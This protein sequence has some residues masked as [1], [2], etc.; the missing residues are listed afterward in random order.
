MNRQ[1]GFMP[2]PFAVRLLPHDPTWAALAE[3]EAARLRRAGGPA[4]LDVHHIGSTAIPGIAAKPVID[5][6]VVATSLAEIDAR[7]PAFESLGYAW[8]GEYGLAGRRYCTLNDPATGARRAQLHCYGQG[9]P[10]IRRHLAFRNYLR[11]R[12][13]LALEYEREKA[14]CAA[15]HPQ[16]SHAY[17]D[18]KGAW[19]RRIEAE[20]L[21]A[22]G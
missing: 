8:H 18:C 12:P 11:A 1:D 9:D 16:D 22:L 13:A 6:I 2:P 21:K 5:L 19:I 7:R 10:S 15:L 4:V 17:S 20:A 14:R 3:A